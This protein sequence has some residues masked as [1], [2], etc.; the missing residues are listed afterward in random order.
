MVFSLACCFS[1]IWLYSYPMNK[2]AGHYISKLFD[3]TL[4]TI[5]LDLKL[6][7][8]NLEICLQMLPLQSKVLF[9]KLRGE[10]NVERMARMAYTHLGSCRDDCRLRAHH[11]IHM[12]DFLP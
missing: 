7:P 6:Y 10:G 3:M 12:A 1:D 8:G 2:A 5:I 9:D 11:F 4:F